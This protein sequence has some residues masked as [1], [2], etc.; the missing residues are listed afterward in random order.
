[1]FDHTDKNQ[2][3]ILFP[4]LAELWKQMYFKNENAWAE[5][6]KQF[7]GTDT[8]VKMLTGT[9]DQHLSME[10]VMRQGLDQYF[11]SIPLPSKKDIARVA[12]I[13]ISLEDKID[14][15]DFEAADIIKKLTE[16]L[17]IMVKAQ[18][19]TKQELEQLK[20]AITDIS[21]KLDNTTQLEENSK[22]ENKK[23][24]EKSGAANKPPVANGGN[25]GAV[26]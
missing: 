24:A 20:K 21:L 22:P 18:E 10:K 6:F 16:N 17:L 19:K 1:M 7:I 2:D 11:D 15:I 12:E 25:E 5:A 13:V 8:F 26:D 23:G 9:L 3:Q 4:N 14:V